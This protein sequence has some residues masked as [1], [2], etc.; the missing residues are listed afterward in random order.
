MPNSTVLVSRRW[1]LVVLLGL[2]ALVGA[3]LM[4]RIYRIG[5]AVSL[6]FP[7]SGVAI[8]FTLWFGPIGAIVTAIASVL[9]APLWGSDGWYRLVGITDG[10][11]PLVAWFLYRRC[12]KGTLSFKHLTD[13]A[14]FILSAPLA[15]CATSAVVGSLTLTFLGKIHFA[16]LTNSILH[17]WLGNAIA[18]M[19]IVPTALLVFTPFLQTRGWLGGADKF[20]IS[21]GAGPTNNLRTLSDNVTLPA[22]PLGGAS[23]LS[24]S[25]CLSGEVLAILIFS[26]ASAVL[27]V[28]QTSS[29]NFAFQQLSFLTFVPIIWAATR[30]GVKGG[31]LTATFCVMVTLLAY[32]L[33]YPYQISLPEFPIRPE[34][35]HVHKLSL[36]MQCAVS[37]L[38]GCAITEKAATSVALAVERVQLVEYQARAEL[39]EQLIQLNQSLAQANERL[40][41]SNRDKDELLLREQ[42]ARTEAETANRLKD[43]FL[44]ILSHELRSP[45]NPILGWTQI[46][47]SRKHDE[48]TAQKAL[49]TIERNTKLQIQLIDD[50]LD[51]SRIIRGKLSL[52]LDR[53]DLVST[54]EAAIETVSL[55]AEAKS[56]NINFIILN[57]SEFNQQKFLVR[58]D[59]T[60][61]QQIIW[62]LLSNAIKFTPDLGNIQVT[63][64]IVIGDKND[65]LPIT[66]YQLPITN[67]A[68]IRVTDTGIGIKADFLPHVFEY[69]RQ[70]DSTTTRKFGGLG[71]GLAIVRHLVELHGG[72]VTAESPGEGQGATFTVKIPLLDANEE[73]A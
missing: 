11:E 26:T 63:L 73:A 57:N 17:W 22:P 43:E 58:G 66:N 31:M 25:H 19:A 60:R 18:T 14:A 55:A 62:N 67:Y 44:A 9:M 51:V 49:E 28:L 30:F 7:P 2:L 21:V 27:T 10:I 59:A 38:V 41:E 47:R 35:L 39:N 61:L 1:W 71:L 32:L 3:H 12:W 52:R 46:L 24:L 70:A 45:L 5:L 20:N 4:A 68:Q 53:V 56:I 50:L 54:I 72:T 33:A 15:A 8:A 29:G 48:K 34:V 37:L 42:K 16:N 40:A 23:S 65:Q 6:W 36:L 13:A 69:F 64:S